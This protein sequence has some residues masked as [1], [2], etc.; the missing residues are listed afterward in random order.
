[1]ALRTG[2][3]SPSLGTAVSVLFRSCAHFAFA[4]WSHLRL[5]AHAFVEDIARGGMK[6]G[7]AKARRMRI[8]GTATSAALAF[9]DITWKITDERQSGTPEILD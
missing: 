7:T 6:F 4:F 2:R 3:K 9:L 5:L 8:T 1:M